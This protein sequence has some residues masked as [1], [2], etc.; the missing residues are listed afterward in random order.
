MVTNS[1]ED[2]YNDI[3]KLLREWYEEALHGDI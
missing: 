1:W 2:D 3:Q